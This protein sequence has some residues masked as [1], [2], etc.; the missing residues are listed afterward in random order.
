MAVTDLP[1]PDSPTSA[2]RAAALERERDAVDRPRGAA[3]L[4]ERDG[5]VPNGQEGWRSGGLLHLLRLIHC[6][7]RSPGSRDTP[8]DAA[9][10]ASDEAVRRDACVLKDVQSRSLQAG[11]GVRVT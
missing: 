4:G 2:K 8:S 7:T 1:D 5:Q 9:S 6:G 10:S 11:M 3:A